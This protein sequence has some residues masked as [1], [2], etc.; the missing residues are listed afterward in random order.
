MF[1]R[2]STIVNDIGKR[3]SVN[4]CVNA[5]SMGAGGEWKKSQLDG[6]R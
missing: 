3:K 6:E 2:C 4:S 5:R 1:V